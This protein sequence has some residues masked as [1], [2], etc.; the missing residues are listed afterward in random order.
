[1]SEAT[2]Y[3]PTGRNGRWPH[4]EAVRSF[5]R[6]RDREGPGVRDVAI[7]EAGHVVVAHACGLKTLSVTA[8]P[9]SEGLGHHRLDRGRTFSPE[10]RARTAFG[11]RAADERDGRF[12]LVR[13]DVRSGDDISA[14]TNAMIIADDNPVTTAALL[15]DAI[16]D[17]RQVVTDRWADVLELASELER[18]DLDAAD[19]V[20]LLGEQREPKWPLV[21]WLA[22]AEGDVYDVVFYTAG[23]RLIAAL[24]YGL[25]FV[26]FESSTRAVMWITTSGDVKLSRM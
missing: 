6:H 2:R 19:L 7:H 11:G 14:L 13:F 12:T 22:K 18:R 26:P 21:D 8:R 24:P 23:A 3:G 1:M 20:R 4:L 10:A 17:A 25:A 5:L 15:V 9:S 16:Q